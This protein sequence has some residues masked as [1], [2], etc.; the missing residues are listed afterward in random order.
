[1]AIVPPTASLKGPPRPAPQPHG[2]H[3]AADAPTSRS[4]AAPGPR[5]QPG[6]W[7]P[8]GWGWPRAA[9]WVPGLQRAS[10]WLWGWHCRCVCLTP[11]SLH[12]DE[13]FQT[14]S[15]GHKQ[16]PSPCPCPPATFVPPAG[17]CPLSLPRCLISSPC[18]PPSLP[19]THNG[20][21]RAHV[22]LCK[23]HA[24]QARRSATAKPP[25]PAPPCVLLTSPELPLGPSSSQ[26]LPTQPRPCPKAPADP[27]ASCHPL[28]PVLLH[29]WLSCTASPG[30]HLGLASGG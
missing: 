1:M 29:L 5:G 27:R 6:P 13:G 22:R 7:R 28:S 15:S 25:K 17:P 12:P 9:V 4:T 11:C 8:V 16:P 14:F 3:R 2:P 21:S 23:Q 26:A 20:F 24:R 19:Y 18:P 10:L 30:H